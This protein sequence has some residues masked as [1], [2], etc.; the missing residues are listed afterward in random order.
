M[1]L[2]RGGCFC[3]AVQFTCTTK[4]RDL[5][6]W[7]CNCSICH[8]KRNL[9]FIVPASKFK[10]EK[11]SEHLKMYQFGTKT[12]KHLFCGV[13]GICPFYVPRSNPDGYG[14]TVW[15]LRPGTVDSI[16]VR[17]YDGQNWEASHSK[18]GIAQH[19]KL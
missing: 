15:C 1:V 13:C 16:D 5:V 4:T 9:H 14:V 10:L 7:D 8:M 6:A 12:A 2:H 11:G 18:T 3:G 19:S 17:S